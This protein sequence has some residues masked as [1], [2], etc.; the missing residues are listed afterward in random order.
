[1]KDTVGV[2]VKLSKKNSSGGAL[3]I[4]IEHHCIL[5]LTLTIEREQRNEAPS[6]LSL[7]WQAKVWGPVTLPTEIEVKGV[8]SLASC[9]VRRRDKNFNMGH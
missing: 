1:M 2:G 7:E 3:T 6:I 8:S 4:P 5:S 9:L